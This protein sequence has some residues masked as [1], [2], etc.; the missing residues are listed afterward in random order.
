MGPEIPVPWRAICRNDNLLGAVEQHVEQVAELVL[1]HLALQELHVVDDQQN[2]VAQ[3]LN[4]L[5][6]QRIVIANSRCEPH[7]KYSAV[8]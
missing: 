3:R 2:R 6:R 7:M 5:E 1:D 4:I 8:R